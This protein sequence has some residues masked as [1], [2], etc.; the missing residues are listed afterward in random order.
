M[1]EPRMEH[2]QHLPT[3]IYR[4]ISL[5]SLENHGKTPEDLKILFLKLKRINS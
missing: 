2:T 1:H 3:Q 4:L 5:F